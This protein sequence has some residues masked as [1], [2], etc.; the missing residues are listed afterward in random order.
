MQIPRK[1]K[2]GGIIYSVIESKPYD[3]AK[4]NENWGKTDFSTLKIMI[5]KDL[6]PQRKEDAFLHEILHACIHTVGLHRQLEDKEEDFVTRL[7][8]IIYQVLK[9]NRLLR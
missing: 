6:P 8:P 3:V 7:S 4:G 1:L 5:D 9:D 2:I